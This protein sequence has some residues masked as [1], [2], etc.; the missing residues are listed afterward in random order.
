M[1][2]RTD[3]MYVIEESFSSTQPET[4]IRTKDGKG[5]FF[6]GTED[7]ARE[8]FDPVTSYSFFASMREFK[9]AHRR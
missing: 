4:F 8:G 1:R 9:A 6:F 3:V 2:L 5:K 7:K